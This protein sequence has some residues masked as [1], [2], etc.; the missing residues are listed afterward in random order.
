MFVFNQYGHSAFD[1]RVVIGTDSV[2]DHIIVHENGVQRTLS[3]SWKEP[4]TTVVLKDAL[5]R[6]PVFMLLST[7]EYFR[8][9]VNNLEVEPAIYIKILHETKIFHVRL[10]VKQTLYSR[11]FVKDFS[12]NPNKLSRTTNKIM[13]AYLKEILYY[14]F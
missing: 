13:S 8:H 10:L 6:N 2:D 12:D 3:K 5:N 9:R 1:I 4:D 11:S 14:P 7:P